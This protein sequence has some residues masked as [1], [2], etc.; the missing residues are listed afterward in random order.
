MAD[1]WLVII[2]VGE[3][4]LDGLPAASRS[5]LD[6]AE[7]VFGAPRHLA[8]LGIAG[9]AWP[10]PFD[11]TPVLA[12][13]GR[14]VVVLASGDPFWHGVGGTLA[15]HLA[16]DEWRALPAPSTPSL[17][18]ARLGWRLEDVI[19]LGLHATPFAR[20]RSV[21]HLGARVIVTLRDGAAATELAAWLTSQGLG[22]SRLWL[23]EAIGG[24][25]E[26]L[27]HSTAETFELIASAPCIMAIEAM[28]TGFLPRSGGLPDSLFAHDG[29]ITKAPVRAMTL[30][31]LAPRRG[32]HLWDIGAGSGSVAVEWC[33]A[34]GTATAVEARA[35]RA[36][37]IRRNAQ[38]FGVDIDVMTATAPECLPGRA[39]DAIFVGGGFSARLFAALPPARLVVNAVTLETESLLIDLH[40]R[41]GGRLLRLDIA[42][43][44]PLGRL[45]GWTP[46]RPITQWSLP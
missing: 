13:R 28:G 4:G 37:N 9:Q 19:C 10:V 44:Q 32:E 29:Q 23:G 40:A 3:D 2:G 34:G 30:S 11:I 1:P 46:S 33:L 39:P 14:P 18:A 17:L 15:A 8:L 5:A 42:E 12:H 6:R 27:R 24:P 41:H 22:A 20:L 35:E 36:D 31:A 26:R 45:R 38:G 7:T 25:R 16:P 21:L 43:V